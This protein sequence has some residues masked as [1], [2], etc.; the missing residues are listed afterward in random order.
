VLYRN[1]G[2]YE[3][4]APL[5]QRVLAI[6]ER[7]LGP[8]HPDTANSLWWMAVVKAQDGQVAEAESFY[9][10]TLSI[11]EKALP[12]QHPNLAKLLDQFAAFLSRTGRDAEAN[13]LKA[14]AEAIRAARQ[15]RSSPG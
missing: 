13:G 6:Y 2:R 4:A 7:A 3:E 14:R 1:Q 5:F 9:R 10:R 15:E 11:F 8:E 12:P